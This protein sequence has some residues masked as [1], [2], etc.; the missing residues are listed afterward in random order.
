MRQSRNVVCLGWLSL[1]RAG[2]SCPDRDYVVQDSS[3]GGRG[4][5]LPLMA[6][7]CGDFPLQWHSFCCLL[8]DRQK[9]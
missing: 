7:C 8:S 3:N 1:A 9:G 6:I 5:Q 2:N 4:I